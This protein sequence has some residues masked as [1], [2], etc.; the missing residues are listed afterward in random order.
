MT[1]IIGIF[2]LLGIAYALSENKKHIDFRLIVWGLSLQLFF[3]ISILKTP[4]GKPLFGFLDKSISKLISF[5]NEGSNF[6]FQSF[7]PDVGYHDAMINFA[8]RALPTIIFF[9]SLMAVLHH[10]KIIQFIIRWIA[11]I[12]QKTMRTSGP[13]TLSVASNIF[14]GQTEAPLVVRPY[15][16][17]MTKSELMVIMVGGFATVAGGVLAMY[18]TWLSDI[19]GIAGHLLA[20]S[21][22]SAPAA[23]V[24]AKIIY[25]ETEN[26]IMLNELKR[27]NEKLS[28]NAMEALGN[29][30]T[31]G[32]KLAGN[33]AAMLIAFISI[34]AMVNYFLSLINL[35]LDQILG[36]L[37]QP[38]A[39]VMGVP[40][41]QSKTFGMLMGKKIA[42]TELIA[43]NDLKELILTEQIS[44][45]T[46][47]I[48]SY[49]LC[50]FANFGSIGIQLGGIGG[51]APERKRELSKLA[52]KAMIGGA[53]AS[54]LTATIAG[55]LI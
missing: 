23:L 4:I 25:P 26:S 18:V 20:A 24:I 5:S 49:A 2:A 35:S 43:Y 39:W 40:W 33:V 10:F 54:W 6:L 38:L 48:A 36:T 31:D 51:I 27:N 11:A 3:A 34:I 13:E 9:S 22:M 41:D 52:L 28:S 19:P 14:V 29:G 16:S 42:F 53:L 55:I 1:G 44:D 32:L 50:G 15:I 37:F 17:K 7:V 45:R 46:A 47:I 12:M 30:A 8:F 21:V